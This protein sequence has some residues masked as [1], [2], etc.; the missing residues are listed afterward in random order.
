MGDSGAALHHVSRPE[1]G[2]GKRRRT[3]TVR[4]RQA[5]P[6]GSDDAFASGAAAARALSGGGATSHS[7]HRPDSGPGLV[8]SFEG[9]SRDE[10]D[11]RRGTSSARRPEP[12]SAA[13]RR[14][15]A[16]AFIAARAAADRHP[17][18]GSC[19]K[20]RAVQS[21]VGARAGGPGVSGRVGVFGFSGYSCDG[22]SI[23]IRMTE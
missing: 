2:L 5:D 11:G 10:T 16:S 12:E 7:S 17:E 13:G 4:A 20:R 15:D 3:S 6:A 14:G 19:G 22:L 8:P 18:V 23:V 21:A 1:R 9:V